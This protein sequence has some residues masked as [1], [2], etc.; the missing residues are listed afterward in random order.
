M[1]SV[2][3]D[4]SVTLAIH[5]TC[6]GDATEKAALFDPVEGLAGVLLFILGRKREPLPG[7]NSAG[8]ETDTQ[9]SPGQTIPYAM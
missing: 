6:T 3:Q 5:A 2:V 8:A 9:V 1:V 4:K 7:N